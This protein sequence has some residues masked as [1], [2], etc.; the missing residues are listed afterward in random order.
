M[1]VLNQAAAGG[2]N[3]AKMIVIAGFIG[4]VMSMSFVDGM[5]KKQ[6]VAALVSGTIMAHYLSSPIAN[7]F[8]H[9]QYRE[10][11][12]FLVGLFGMSIC[13]AIFRSIKDSNLWELFE[14]RFGVS[15]TSKQEEKDL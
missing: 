6:R 10:T 3:S 1:E 8:S 11:I 12:G 9:G 13:A 14:K 15:P 5:N 7:S 4:S 2:E